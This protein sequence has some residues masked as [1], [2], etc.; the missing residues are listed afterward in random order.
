MWWH[1]FQLCDLVKFR[2]WTGASKLLIIILLAKC[3]IGFTSVQYFKFC[4]I[5]FLQHS[6]IVCLPWHK[7]Q[8]EGPYSYRALGMP[9]YHFIP[10]IIMASVD[11]LS[12]SFSIIQFYQ[13]GWNVCHF[14][15]VILCHKNFFYIFLLL[16]FF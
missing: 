3:K 10:I 11:E 5:F 8:F 4:V 6:E 16:L 12:S 15:P 1:N 9:A 13:N 2:F 14:H 7:H